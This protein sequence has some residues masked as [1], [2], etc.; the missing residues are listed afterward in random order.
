LNQVLVR[1]R[2]RDFIRCVVEKMF[3]YALGR[4]LEYYDR[5]AVESAC[6]RLESGGLKFSTLIQGVTESVPF[7]FRRGDGDP[8]VVS[9]P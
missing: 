1:S 6:A 9:A 7:Q 8:L 4:G 3:T 5:P 2:R